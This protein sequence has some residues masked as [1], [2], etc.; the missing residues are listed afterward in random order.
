MTLSAPSKEAD[1]MEREASDQRISDTFEL[2][3]LEEVMNFK[4]RR[5][6]DHLTTAYR[7][8]TGRQGLRPGVFSLLA[9]IEANPR[10]SQAE[11]ARFAGYDRTALVGIMDDLEQ[12]G[13]AV[14]HKDVADRRRH[15]VEITTKGRQALAVLLERALE[16][17]RP[18]REALSAVE[19]SE[20]HE[21]LDKIYRRLI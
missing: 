18:A 19:F 13:W 21:A 8:E 15:Q 2:G 10:Y 7:R 17:E 4:L 3:V 12:R 14:R 20:F 9:L 16:N 11:L 6:R 1:L 5:I